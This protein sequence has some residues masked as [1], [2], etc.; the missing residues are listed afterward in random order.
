M[1]IIITDRTLLEQLS[2]AS[3]TVELH[4]A[5]G[6]LLGTFAPTYGK[7]PPGVRSPFSDQELE[8]RRQEPDG[9]RLTDILRDLE[10]HA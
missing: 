7:L 4:D 9:R 1:S 2:R 3:G 5:N 8:R 6:N 10:K